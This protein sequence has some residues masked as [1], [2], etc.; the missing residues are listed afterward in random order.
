MGGAAVVWILFD[1]KAMSSLFTLIYIFQLWSEEY[2]HSFPRRERLC[3]RHVFLQVHTVISASIYVH[4]LHFLC[5]ILRSFGCQARCPWTKRVCFSDSLLL[6][7][8]P[9][10]VFWDMLELTG[11]GWLG[12]ESEEKF[13]FDR[14]W[15]ETD[16][17]S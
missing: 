3:V 6:R 1:S 10:V 9:R 11:L 4:L 16:E 15:V 8:L 14:L 7:P 2:H 12:F 17:V 5:W 13:T